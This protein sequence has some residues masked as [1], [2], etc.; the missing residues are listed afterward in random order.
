M[1]FVVGLTGGIGSGKSIVA[2]AFAE[3]GIDVTDTDR[4]AHGLTA[5]GQVGYALVLEAFGTAFRRPDGTLDRARL[6]ARVFADDDARTRLEAILHP[7]IRE[8]AAREITG[9]TSPYGILVVPLLLE[10]AGASRVDRVLV[11]DCPEEVQIRRV[12]QRSGLS[13]AEVRAIMA[14]QLPRAQ[15]LAR[16]DDVLDNS[17]PLSAIATQVDALDQRYRALA[18]AANQR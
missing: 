11:V 17:G 18:A 15:R 14:T 13:D 10:R 3:R 12:A 2:D 6:R 9:W 16:A 5:P 4:L 8:A 7:L 1:T